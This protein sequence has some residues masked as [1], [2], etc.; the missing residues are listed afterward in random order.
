MQTTQGYHHMDSEMTPRG[1]TIAQLKPPHQGPFRRVAQAQRALSTLRST[2]FS[3]G[4]ISSPNIV[5]TV[6]LSTVDTAPKRQNV[7]LTHAVSPS[8]PEAHA[9]AP[10]Q[11]LIRIPIRTVAGTWESGPTG[12]PPPPYGR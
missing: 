5:D 2:G 11:L 4:T 9:L 7:I 3:H 10:P 12:A 6:C 1:T 8:A